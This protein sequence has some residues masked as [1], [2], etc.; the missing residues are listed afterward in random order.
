MSVLTLFLVKQGCKGKEGAYDAEVMHLIALLHLMA[1]VRQ[2]FRYFLRGMQACYLKGFEYICGFFI[3]VCYSEISL[4]SLAGIR[5]R[6][7]VHAL[8]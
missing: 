4:L 7:P 6:S 8:D 3:C 2:L 5:I 1:C